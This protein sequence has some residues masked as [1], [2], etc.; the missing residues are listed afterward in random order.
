MVLPAYSNIFIVSIVWGS[1]IL[2]IHYLRRYS[3]TPAKSAS[4]YQDV[5]AGIGDR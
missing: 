5:P 1:A 3:N 4:R 2:L